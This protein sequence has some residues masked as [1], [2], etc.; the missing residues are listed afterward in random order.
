MSNPLLGPQDRERTAPA[1][2]SPEG[3]EGVAHRDKLAACVFF[4]VFFLIWLVIVLYLTF[5]P[6]GP[7]QTWPG[8][9]GYLPSGSIFA[10]LLS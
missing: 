5:G 4:A 2:F 6:G 8:G 9:P 7:N 1:T 10:G 3:E